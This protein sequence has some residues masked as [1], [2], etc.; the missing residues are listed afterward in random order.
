MGHIS[1]N[2]MNN[3]MKSSRR[4]KNGTLL[5]HYAFVTYVSTYI[6][7]RLIPEMLYYTNAAQRSV[8]HRKI[9]K[10]RKLSVSVLKHAINR[11]KEL[12]AVV[13]YKANLLRRLQNTLKNI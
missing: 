13:P 9:N 8:L 4:A 10:L 6:V 5:D 2:T 1:L 12:P 11:V 7:G 3:A